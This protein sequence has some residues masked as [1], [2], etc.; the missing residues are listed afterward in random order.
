MTHATRQEKISLVKQLTDLGYPPGRYEITNALDAAIFL[1]RTTGCDVSQ[2]A[3]EFN[4]SPVQRIY[5]APLYKKFK[6]G[7][8][9]KIGGQR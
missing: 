1:I 7:K 3:R 4:I 5:N 9:A 2:A 8:L 6:A